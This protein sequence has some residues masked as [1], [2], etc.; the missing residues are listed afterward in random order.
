MRSAEKT[1]TLVDT[2]L[3]SGIVANIFI[4]VALGASMKR[5]FS[6]LNTLQI[7]THLSLLALPLPTNLKVCIDTLVQLSTL[8]IIPQGW[9][10]YVMNFIDDTASVTTG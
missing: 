2:S 5:M 7:M 8:S 1:F 3:A 6:L 4:A 9:V 10:D